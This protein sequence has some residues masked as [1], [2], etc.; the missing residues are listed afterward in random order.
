MPRY[1][2][3]QVAKRLHLSEFQLLMVSR[4]FQLSSPGVQ[5]VL[6]DDKE[7]QLLSKICQKLDKHPLEA[8]QAELFP[9]QPPP[10]ASPPPETKA[11]LYYQPPAENIWRRTRSLRL[12][13]RLPGFT[14]PFRLFPSVS[15]E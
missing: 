12:S 3:G 4:L 1:S 6:F 14:N 15:E 8:V 7:V 2:L 13:N 11:R 5:D 9:T 10:V